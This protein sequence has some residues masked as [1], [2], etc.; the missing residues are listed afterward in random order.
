M[1]SDIF[2]KNRNNFYVLVG[3]FLEFFDLY[4]YVHL[5][6][7]IHKYFF[8]GV[9]ESL[10]NAFTFVNLYLCAPIGCIIFAYLGDIVGR[11]QV[12][13]STS[14]IMAFCSTAIGILPA[15]E[16]IGATAGVCLIILRVLQGISLSGEP[17]AAS[18]YL[19]ESTPYKATPLVIAIISATQ[20]LGGAVAL[21]VGYLAI[22]WGGDQAWR[23]PFYLGSFFCL[24]SIWLRWNLAESKEYLEYTSQHKIL[25]KQEKEKTF[26]QFYRSLKFQQRNFFSWIGMS[27]V[28]S[29]AFGISYVYLGNYL[30]SHL[31]LS[32]HTLLL[33]NFN[34]TLCE[35]TAVLLEGFLVVNF[36]LNVKKF[37]MWRTGLFLA[38]LPFII[39]VFTDSPSVL[40]IFGVQV[41]IVVCSDSAIIAGSLIKV[42]PVLGRYSLVG[43]GWA[44][45]KF[46]NF[47]LSGVVLNFVS[48]SYPIVWV[49]ALMLPVSLMYL[50]SIFSYAPYIN[51]EK[52]DLPMDK[53]TAL[54]A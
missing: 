49:V 36:N 50:F 37:I 16:A 45:G 42:F 39:M 21:G 20:C 33:H 8:V 2:Q 4:M 23:V 10:L 41:A 29:I 6:H 11:K 44:A 9:H 15:H 7:I 47:F 22:D 28:Y 18:V 25:Y 35:M 52:K 1:I 46:L 5:A 32:E 17:I 27:C 31:G 3:T 54:A 34:V 53:K 26:V 40:I 51:K 38:A 13:V 43:I 12:I 14:F 19:I 24:F 30:V 48:V